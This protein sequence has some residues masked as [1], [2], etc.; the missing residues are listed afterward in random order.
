MQ[1]VHEI[2]E[3]EQMSKLRVLANPV[4]DYTILFPISQQGCDKE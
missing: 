1:E 3:I 2:I 4:W